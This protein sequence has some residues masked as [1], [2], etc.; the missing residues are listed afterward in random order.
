MNRMRRAISTWL[1]AV[2][3]TDAPMGQ[4]CLRAAA[5]LSLLLAKRDVL[6]FGNGDETGRISAY[7]ASELNNMT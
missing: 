2:H 1:P 5:Q 3:R 7:G 4:V 6:D